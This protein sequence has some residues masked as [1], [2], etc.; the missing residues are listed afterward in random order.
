VAL[1]RPAVSMPRLLAL[2]LLAAA[3]FSTNFVLN[4]AISLGG[5]DWVWSAAL[6]YFYT[7]L[8][9]GG[10]LLWR[11]GAG[12]LG[13]V[14]SMFWRKRRF[15]LLTGGVGYGLFYA[16]LCF[17]ANHAPAW[18]T[19]AT[20]QLTILASPFV[21]RAFGKKVP[22]HGIAF[23]V[24]IFLGVVIINAQ[25]RLA[26]I[27]VAQVLAGVL[28]T[29]IAAFAYPI[30]NQFVSEAKHAE[31][32]DARILADP[33]TCVFLM[34]LGALPVFLALLL[35]TLPGPPT[36][37]QMV[38]TA[39]IAVFAGCLATTLFLYAR[40]LSNDPYRIAAVDA[41][42]AGEV[43]FALIGEMMVLGTPYMGVLSWVGLGAVM[44][45]LLGFTLWRRNGA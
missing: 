20:F 19:A 42:Q 30:G 27:P 45:G 6:R 23:L 7:A 5:G 39:I 43:A 22:L 38:S 35:V 26:G 34:T 18:V 14:F 33:I 31:G 8:L 13:V 11:R 17:A 12:Y 1:A 4:R 32:E 25:R 10:W 40:N 36:G 44:G 28:P 9:L 41:T 15:W 29:A 16:C 21:L 24:L 3:M 2:G 37:Q